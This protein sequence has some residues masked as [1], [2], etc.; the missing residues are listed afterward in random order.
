MIEDIGTL[1]DLVVNLPYYHWIQQSHAASDNKLTIVRF[2]SVSDKNRLFQKLLKYGVLQGNIPLL[3]KKYRCW[4]V[5]SDHAFLQANGLDVVHI[6]KHLFH[7]VLLYRLLTIAMLRRLNARALYENRRATPLVRLTM[8]CGGVAAA[9]HLGTGTEDPPFTRQNWLRFLL[10]T[11]YQAESFRRRFA[12]KFITTFG[13]AVTIHPLVV[14]KQ[15]WHYAGSIQD[16]TIQGNH[17]LESNH[18][19]VERVVPDMP[20]SLQFRAHLPYTPL[21]AN[22]TA[23]RPV[24]LVSIGAGSVERNLAMDNWRALIR[25][26]T[27]EHDVMVASLPNRFGELMQQMGVLP[28]HALK[29]LAICPPVNNYGVFGH[30]LSAARLVVCEDTGTAHLALMVGAPCV[31][32][33]PYQTPK[34]FLPYPDEVMAPPQQQI[35]Y[36]SDEEMQLPNPATIQ[37]KVLPRVLEALA[38]NESSSANSPTPPTSSTPPTPHSEALT[39]ETLANATTP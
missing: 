27:D 16:P 38:A 8:A 6:D 15:A 14:D 22:L 28:N 29:R 37:Q 31:V 7:N 34:S 21:V 13:K 4:R 17:Y 19:L 18:A 1:G 2:I 23:G 10:R 24:I 3:R 39:S 33:G 12:D 9:I 25:H 11:P 20:Q 30:Y 26:L 5:E 32:V 35:V 36:L